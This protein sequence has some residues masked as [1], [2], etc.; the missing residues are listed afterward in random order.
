M[1]RLSF[2]FSKNKP[3]Q[4]FIT[5][6]VMIMLGIF[7]GMSDIPLLNNIAQII[8]DLFIKMFRFISLPLI[9]LSIIVTISGYQAQQSM[10]KIWQRT[11]AYTLTTTLIAASVSCLLYLLISPENVATNI[12][13][14]NATAAL[15]T[16]Y[17]KHIANL[18]PT[19]IFSP[20]LEHQ[21]MGVLLI[22]IV[23]GIAIRYIPD[24]QAK[25]SVQGFFKGIHAIFLVIT[26]WIVAIIPIA[27]FGFI[28]TTVLQLRDGM[29]IRSIA[30]YL[31]VVVFA[32]LIQGL[33]ILPLWLKM[34]GIDPFAMMRKMMPAL[35]VA[36]FTKSSAG[37]LPV[38]MNT[39]EKQLNV[40]PKVSR[41]IL[42]MCTGINMNGCA[43]FIFA[44][45]IF[46][47]QNN[48]VEISLLTMA[49]WVI[50]ATIA[51][52]GNAGVPMGC[53]FLSASLLTSMDIPIKLLGMILPFYSI[54]DMIETSLNVWSDS[55]VTK[56]ISQKIQPETETAKQEQLA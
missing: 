50:V 34:N 20:F 14:V 10:Q 4:L 54:I 7:A 41:F 28:A 38:T 26:K 44:T 1:M 53:F 39:I 56:V 31:S 45:V 48:G 11:I 13:S 25:N 35:S 32:N 19:S 27:L 49:I 5:Y 33:I 23:L 36:F 15:E 9:A 8:S 17:L 24:D 47:M 43:A 16:N 42:P 52:I 3:Y 40:D 21:V 46:L 55:C 2:K 18:I 37:T 30:A 22:G 12:P 29:D 6:L 51:A